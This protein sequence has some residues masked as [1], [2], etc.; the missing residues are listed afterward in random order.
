MLVTVSSL[1]KSFNETGKHISLTVEELH[2]EIARSCH[3]FCETLLRIPNSWCDYFCDFSDRA[4][5]WFAGALG[6][7]PEHSDSQRQGICYRIKATARE[8]DGKDVFGKKVV[9]MAQPDKYNSDVTGRTWTAMIADAE[10]CREGWTYNTRQ[11]A[12]LYPIA[13]WLPVCQRQDG[14]PAFRTISSFPAH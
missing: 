12:E 11:S 9:E 10:S 5:K 7:G 2:E 6:L 4:T 14:P 3:N 13:G 8:K 1:A